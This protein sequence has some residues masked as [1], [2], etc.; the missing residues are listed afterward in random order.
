M[1]SNIAE[2]RLISDPKPEN[3]GRQRIRF[4]AGGLGIILKTPEENFLITVLRTSKSS[5]DRH[6]TAFTGVGCASEIADPEKT[7]VRKGLEDLIIVTAGKVVLPRFNIA[8]F[9]R[10]N[11]EAVVRDGAALHAET[12]KLPLEEARGTILN[13]KNEKEFRIRWRGKEYSYRGLPV[14]DAGTRGLDFV[15]V[16]FIELNERIEEITCLDGRI[17][18]GKNC[19]NRTIYALSL[20]KNYDLAGGINCGW[21]W[22]G[23]KG[24]YEYFIPPKETKFPRT[25]ILATIIK[26][27]ADYEGR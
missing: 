3:G 9:S 10:I 5:F 17:M 1:A 26:E 21:R 25:P 22:N 20:D 16:T 8:S 15:K 6:L 27:L 2:R 24:K 4:P 13:L 11:I 19:L 18:G 14:F 23:N 7:A 12:E